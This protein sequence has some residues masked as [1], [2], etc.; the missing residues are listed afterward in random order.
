MPRLKEDSPG[1]FD[2][3]AGLPIILY[4]SPLFNSFT[5]FIPFVILFVDFLFIYVLFI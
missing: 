3:V 1:Q 5:A 2:S 4:L